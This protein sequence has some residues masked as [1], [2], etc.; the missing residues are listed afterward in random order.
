MAYFCVNEEKSKNCKF[1][2][3][4]LVVGYDLEGKKMCNILSHESKPC[5]SECVCIGE[6]KCE[7]RT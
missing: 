2:F 4:G 1:L 5:E 3:G 7:I 6:C